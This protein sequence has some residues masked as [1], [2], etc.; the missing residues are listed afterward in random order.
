MKMVRVLKKNP[1]NKIGSQMYEVFDL[2][3]AYVLEK[4]LLSSMNL[5]KSKQIKTNLKS[6]KF[7][8]TSV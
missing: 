1:E 3:A 4:L 5:I 8:P 2:N 6:R 7:R